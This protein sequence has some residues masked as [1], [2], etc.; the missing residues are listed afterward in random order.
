[1]V[2]VN[3]LLHFVGHIECCAS[4]FSKK[5]G[6]I[7][8]HHGKIIVIDVSNRGAPSIFLENGDAVFLLGAVLRG[9]G[10]FNIGVFSNGQS[11]LIAG[12]VGVRVASRR[13]GHLHPGVRLLRHGGDRCGTCRINHIDAI[14]IIG[15][16]AG[17]MLGK[18][19]IVIIDAAQRQAF[20]IVVRRERLVVGEYLFIHVRFAPIRHVRQSG[21][22]HNI[23]GG[24]IRKDGLRVKIVGVFQ[25]V[26]VLGFRPAVNLN[27]LRCRR[28]FIGV[29]L[30]IIR[31]IGNPEALSVRPHALRRA[32]RLGEGI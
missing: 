13:L 4:V 10:D 14:R 28:Q 24:S 1:M 21:I 23:H 17:K 30:G 5:A 29:Y 32:I 6:G 25:C 15:F 7:G 31:A 2:S 19:L 16:I 22:A 26:E 18:V 27:F 12:G 3:F 20:Q 11:D 8:V 9:D